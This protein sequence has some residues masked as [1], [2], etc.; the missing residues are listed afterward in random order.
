[1]AIRR[2]A[3]GED[4]RLAAVQLVD[5]LQAEQRAHPRWSERYL[6]CACVIEE[7]TR[8]ITREAK[9]VAVYSNYNT[10]HVTTERPVPSSEVAL[11]RF[12]LDFWRKHKANLTEFFERC[13]SIPWTQQVFKDYQENRANE[14][15][16]MVDAFTRAR[17][18]SQLAL[19]QSEPAY[20]EQC[21]QLWLKRD[22]AAENEVDTAKRIIVLVLPAQQ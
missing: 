12:L 3:T 8:A 18:R 7:V 10:V 14:I 16:A 20:K 9:L 2:I 22:E 5:A 6:D 11:F 15:A 4:D 17:L 13:K 21:L 1:M 19:L